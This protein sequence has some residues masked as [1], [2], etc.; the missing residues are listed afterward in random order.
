MEDGNSIV[1]Y[2]LHIWAVSEIMKSCYSTFIVVIEPG[3]EKRL[4]R[5]DFFV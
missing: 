4:G 2:R 1:C 5:E 3:L